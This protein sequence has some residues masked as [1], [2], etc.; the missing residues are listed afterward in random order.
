ME[1][2]LSYQR[3][4]T[5]MSLRITDGTVFLAELK[6][7]RDGSVLTFTDSEREGISYR[8]DPDGR[9]YMFYEDVEIPIDPSDELKCRDWL[10]LFAIPADENIWRIKKESLGGIAVYVCRDGRITLYLDAASGLPLRL[11]ADGVQ[12]DVLSAS[13]N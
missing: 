3:P 12:I 2:L 1:T 8:A 5:E 6:L 4:G 7:T 13:T 9:I 11:E 10:A